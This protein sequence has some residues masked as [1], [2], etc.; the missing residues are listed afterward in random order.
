MCVCV[1]VYKYVYIC[2]RPPR[3]DMDLEP[4][5]ASSQHRESGSRHTIVPST[6]RTLRAVRQSSLSL[7][8]SVM[9]TVG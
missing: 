4:F 3:V 6:P 2:D 1:C 7:R 8:Q 5:S 9:K